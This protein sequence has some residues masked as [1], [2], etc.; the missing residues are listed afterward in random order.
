MSLGTVLESFSGNTDTSGNLTLSKLTPS[1]AKW[2]ALKVIG[3]T[4]GAGRWTIQISGTARVFSPG[5]RCDDA[6]YA[7]PGSWWTSSC[8]GPTRGSWSRG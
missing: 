6:I 2:A 5:N 3:Q 4:Q 1:P 8:R 7:A